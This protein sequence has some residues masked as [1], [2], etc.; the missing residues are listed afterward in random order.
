M[1]GAN[2][3]GRALLNMAALIRGLTEHD[4]LVE[5]GERDCHLEDLS[6]SNGVEMESLVEMDQ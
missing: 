2:A 6:T 5:G 1:P 3:R 4:R